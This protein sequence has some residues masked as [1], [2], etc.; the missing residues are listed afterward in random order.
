M[1]KAIGAKSI[2]VTRSEAKEEA[3]LAVG[4]DQVIIAA[5]SERMGLE[6][7]HTI[8]HR[9]LHPR[10]QPESSDYR[11]WRG[12]SPRTFVPQKTR[13]PISLLWHFQKV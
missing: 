8:R 10:H 1:A 12:Y 7:L 6:W 11:D 5:H 2:A 13:S 9:D 4:A 3:L